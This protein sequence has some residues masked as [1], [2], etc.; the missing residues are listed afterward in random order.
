MAA[1]A[2]RDPLI[3]LRRLRATFGDVRVLVLVSGG[4]SPSNPP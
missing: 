1:P 4:G 2:D 3:V